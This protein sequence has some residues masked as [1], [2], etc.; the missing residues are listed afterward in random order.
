MQTLSELPTLVWESSTL[1]A[2]LRYRA[3]PLLSP[4]ADYSTANLYMWDDTY[5]EELAF[6]GTR[7]AGRIQEEDG[8][9]RYLFPVGEGALEPVLDALWQEALARDGVLRFVGVAEEE[10][11]YLVAKWGEKMQILETREWADYLYDA[12]KLSTLSGKK[13]HA[14]RNHINAFSAAHEWYTE[15]LSPAHF[16]VCF[17]ILKEWQIGRAEGIAEEE[18]AIERAFEAWEALELSGLVLFADG[19]PVAFTV[20][21]RITNECLCVH[22]E[23]ALPAFEGAYPV[24]NREF[25]RAMREKYPALTLINREDDMGLENLRAAKLS[26]R[27]LALLRK[28]DVTIS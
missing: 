19:I 16:P 10:M 21:S 3:L 9:Y 4:S 27:P 24:I 28:F 6:V 8:C 15:A 22:F 18:R 14:K 2:C 17:E 12:E 7:A 20:G 26:W 23:K 1:E 25:A 5:H 13:L 11:P